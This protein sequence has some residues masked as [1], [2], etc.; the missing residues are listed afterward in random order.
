MRRGIIIAIIVGFLSIAHNKV[1]ADPIPDEVMQ[2]YKAFS[3]A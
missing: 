2:P 3:N 1:Y